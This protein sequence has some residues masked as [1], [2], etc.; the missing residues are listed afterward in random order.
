MTLEL[1]IVDIN[2][3]MTQTENK[4]ESCLIKLEYPTNHLLGF[5]D[6][7]TATE[8]SGNE[9]II[10]KKALWYNLIIIPTKGVSVKNG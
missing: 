1:Q 2:P 6:L 7:S 10:I 9:Y 8:L 5:D 3:N 4:T